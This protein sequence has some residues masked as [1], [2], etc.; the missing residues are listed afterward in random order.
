MKVEQAVIMP[1]K[2][3]VDLEDVAATLMKV[4]KVEITAVPVMVVLLV[5]QVEMVLLFVGLMVT[6]WLILQMQEI[7]QEIRVPQV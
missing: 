1:M 5:Q 6:S 2:L 4:L 7:S 3:L